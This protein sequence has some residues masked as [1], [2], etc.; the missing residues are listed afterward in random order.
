MMGYG[1]EQREKPRVVVVGHCAIDRMGHEPDHKKFAQLPEDGEISY[2]QLV[3]LYPE[4]RTKCYNGGPVLNLAQYLFQDNDVSVVS[5]LGNDH[6]SQ[7]YRK[8]LGNMGIDTRKIRER[9]GE[10]STCVYITGPNPS[11]PPK[12]YWF[13]NAAT[14][15]E[16]IKLNR[17][18]FLAQDAMILAVTEPSI[19]RRAAGLFKEVRPQSPLFYNPGQYLEYLPFDDTFFTDIIYHADVLSVNKK[20]AKIVKSHMHLGPKIEDLFKLEGVA[21]NL[22]VI[23]RTKG[24]GGSALYKKEDKSVE[25]YTYRPKRI[26]GI[27]DRIGAGDALNGTAFNELIKHSR[28]DQILYIASKVAEESLTF[29]GAVNPRIQVDLDNATVHRSVEL[30]VDEFSNG[31]FDIDP[32]LLLKQ[33]G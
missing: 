29:K 28:L 7:N 5:V 26:R 13:D 11:Q 30:E 1:T 32:N 27:I 21:P 18:F 33:S 22:D 3:K 2:K 6:Q 10:I 25:T 15:F 20:E 4:I 12:E 31:D 9:E 19:A 24:A 23:I 8:F 14:D 17:D 16:K